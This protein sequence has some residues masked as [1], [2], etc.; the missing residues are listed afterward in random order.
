MRATERLLEIEEQSGILIDRIVPIEL[1]GQ[2]LRLVLYLKDGTNLRLTEQWNGWVLERYSYDW[3][4]ADNQLKIG[5]DN[6]PHPARY[7]SPSQTCC[8]SNKQT[9]IER[10]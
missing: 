7:F 10:N 4:T 3:L 2:A 8:S 9:S 6:A 1:D 5:G